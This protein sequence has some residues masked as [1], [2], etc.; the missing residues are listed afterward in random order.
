MQYDRLNSILAGLI[1][2]TL[3]VEP[4]SQETIVKRVRAIYG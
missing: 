1:G 3:G 4:P 2:K